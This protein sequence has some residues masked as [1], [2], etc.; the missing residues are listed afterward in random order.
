MKVSQRLLKVLQK[1]FYPQNKYQYLSNI[2]EE[3]EKD[4][5]LR[6]T[7]VIANGLWTMASLAWILSIYRIKVGLFRWYDLIIMTLSVG[8]F[9]WFTGSLY[10]FLRQGWREK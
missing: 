6:T 8:S 5:V 9:W 2:L 4:I 7:E 10:R 1:Y 3:W